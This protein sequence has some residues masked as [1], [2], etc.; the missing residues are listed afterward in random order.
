MKP[1]QPLVSATG[2]HRIHT[3]K[4]NIAMDL[5]DVSYKISEINPQNSCKNPQ[6]WWPRNGSNDVNANVP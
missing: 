4:E 1:L 3:Q 6:R 2:Y 5:G